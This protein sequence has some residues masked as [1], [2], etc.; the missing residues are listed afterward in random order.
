VIYGFSELTKSIAEEISIKSGIT[1]LSI[2][3]FA[4]KFEPEYDIASK[5]AVISLRWCKCT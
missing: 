3:N 4:L 2:W 1:L 5:F